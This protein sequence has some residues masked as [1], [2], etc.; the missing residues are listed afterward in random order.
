MKDLIA[1]M[2]PTMNDGSSDSTR[3]ETDPQAKALIN[4]IQ[5]TVST[6][7]SK[8]AYA[9][10]RGETWVETSKEVLNFYNPNGMGKN[11]FFS[12]NGIL[13]CEFGKIDECENSMNADLQ[14]QIHGQQE[15]VRTESNTK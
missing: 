14:R 8:V 4:D 11:Q 2:I 7:E 13:V 3:K 9:K 1:R 6:F 10:N 15:G 5:E 12:Y